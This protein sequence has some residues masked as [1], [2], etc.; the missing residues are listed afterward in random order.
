MPFKVKHYAQPVNTN[1][2]GSVEAAILEF[3][4]GLLCAAF[5]YAS[6]D[7]IIQLYFSMAVLSGVCFL[8][9]LHNIYIAIKIVLNNKR[10]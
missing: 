3:L 6:R 1:V 10:A 5:A 4:I 7:A 9:T 2:R 8:L